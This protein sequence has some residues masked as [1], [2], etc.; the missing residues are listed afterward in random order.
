VFEC[1]NTAAGTFTVSFNLSIASIFRALAIARYSGVDTSV[2]G[3]AARQAQ[4]APGTGTDAVSSTNLTPGSQPGVLVGFGYDDGGGGA[5]SAGTGFTSR[6]TMSNMDTAFGTTSRV[7]D[8]A[9]TSTSAVAATFTG[10]NGRG[11]LHHLRGV[12]ARC[13]G[14]CGG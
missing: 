4:A 5:V 9:I 1:K 14:R 10:A 2:N 8:K 6:G 12:R 3:V 11:Q 7:E 13:C